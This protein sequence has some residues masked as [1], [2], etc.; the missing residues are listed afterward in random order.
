MKVTLA[1]LNDKKQGSTKRMMGYQKVTGVRDS[2]RDTDVQNR[3]MDTV[4]EGECG[5]SWENGNETCK[6]SCRK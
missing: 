4:G 3:L 5:K 6:I 1:Y 2:K